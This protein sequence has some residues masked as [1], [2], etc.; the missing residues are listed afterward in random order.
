MG[1]YSEGGQ[2]PHPFDKLRAGSLAKDARRV[3]QPLASLDI[4]LVILYIQ[5]VLK[6]TLWP[7]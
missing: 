4:R 6:E 2:N 5:S 7:N 1:N 3:G